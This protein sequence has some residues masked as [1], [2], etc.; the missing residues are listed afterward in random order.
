MY[1]E[2]Q[3]LRRLVDDLRTLSLTDAGELH[4]ECQ[5]IP[6]QM[7][8]ER[9]AAV[10][11]QRAGEKEI[12][13]TIQVEPNVPDVHVDQDRLTQV[14]SNLIDNA[15]RY[16][17][18]GGEITLGALAQDDV[19]LITVQD[20]GVGIPPQHLPHVFDRFYRGDSARSRDGGESGLGLAIAKAIIEAHGGT[21]SVDSTPGAGTTFTIALD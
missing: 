14:L 9:L 1:V 15:L 11:R 4:M 17:P 5:A 21:I 12:A 3:R 18:P 13:L 2:T 8:L 10:Y 6:P 7:L 19:T 16:T 20:T